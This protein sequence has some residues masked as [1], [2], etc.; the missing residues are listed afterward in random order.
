MPNLLSA[1]FFAYL[2]G[3]TGLSVG[4][5]IELDIVLT[6]GAAPTTLRYAD[7]EA[8]SWS[9]GHYDGLI[10]EKGAGEGSR[11]V[12][13]FGSDL[14]ISGTSVTLIDKD[15]RWAKL[16]RG[17][18]KRYLPGSAVRIYMVSQ[19]LTSF[20]DAFLETSMVIK[21]W[22]RRADFEITFNLKPDMVLLERAVPD[23]SFTEALYPFADTKVWGLFA[24][25]A[26]GIF[27]SRPTH[28]E[29]MLPAHCVDRNEFRWFHTVGQTEVTAVFKDG[30]PWT[31]FKQET[32]QRGGYDVTETVFPNGLGEGVKAEDVSITWDGRGYRDGLGVLI[33]NPVSQ[34]A[35]WLRNFL[36]GNPT[37]SPWHTGAWLGSCPML[38]VAALSGFIRSYNYFFQRNLTG[39]AYI[40]A[41]T[42]RRG[43]EVLNEWATAWH[44]KPYLMH[45]GQLDVWMLDPARRRPNGDTYYVWGTDVRFCRP[46]EENGLARKVM[47]QY[48]LDPVAN[49]YGKN[50]E[51][52][53]PTVPRNQGVF[54]HQLS[55]GPVNE[56]DKV[57]AASAPD[58]A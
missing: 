30:E 52:T 13:V 5:L 28:G 4:W 33:T 45:N 17:P 20:S 2:K 31:D 34:I 49:Q 21:D 54:P 14:Q 37:G 50:T 26:Y 40:P 43:L 48:H 47:V 6:P 44:L 55:W 9:R 1:P 12:P 39:S 11:G 10:K 51:T 3:Q 18:V 25:F 8:A 58:A 41:S 42:Q 24:P 56:G 35:H 29:G 46:K 53:D 23:L 38:N 27:D 7:A 19:A 15:R 32:V 22:D 57:F 36:F 16:I